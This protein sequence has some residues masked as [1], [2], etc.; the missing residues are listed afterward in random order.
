[1]DHGKI[2]PV[3]LAIMFSAAALAGCVESP[4][5]F[6]APIPT[7]GS[8]DVTYTDSGPAKVLAKTKIGANNLYELTPGKSPDITCFILS[9]IYMGSAVSGSI[10]CAA[11]SEDAAPPKEHA[12]VTSST[13]LDRNIFYEITPATRQDLRCFASTSVY[14]GSAVSGT[15]RC[16]PLASK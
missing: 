9:S 5:S 1:M 6:P 2:L 4:P 3:A 16:F 7:T 13:T 10:E 15:I 11:K 8:V 14:T 12:T